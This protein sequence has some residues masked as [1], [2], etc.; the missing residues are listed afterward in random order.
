M[1]QPNTTFN[2][3]IRDIEIIEQAPRAQAGRRG[4]AI[5]PR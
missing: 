4:M 3:T 1:P 5:V 2:P